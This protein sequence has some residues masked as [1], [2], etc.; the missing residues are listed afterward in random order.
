MK[1]RNAE[2][3]DLGCGKLKRLPASSNL[4]VPSAFAAN[5]SLHGVKGDLAASLKDRFDSLIDDM[6]NI[7][8]R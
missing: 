7:T 1:R 4:F 2:W 6:D 8:A 3:I 5:T